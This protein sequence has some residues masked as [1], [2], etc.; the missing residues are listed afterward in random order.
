MKHNLSHY[1]SVNTLLYTSQY[2]AQSQ[3]GLCYK[4]HNFLIFIFNTVLKA[5]QCLTIYLRDSVINNT[6]TN[7]FSNKTVILKEQYRTLRRSRRCL[8]SITSHSLSI[9]VLNNTISHSL[10]VKTLYTQP[11]NYKQTV[12]LFKIPN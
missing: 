1:L 3:S 5:T 9:Y 2:L 10:F 6:I 12:V 8:N 11:K 4:Q 7:S